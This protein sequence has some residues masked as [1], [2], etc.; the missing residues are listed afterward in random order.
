MGYV[1]SQE[2]SLF[3]PLK[4]IICPIHSAPKASV[5]VAWE[6]LLRLHG[7]DASWSIFPNVEWTEPER[8]DIKLDAFLPFPKSGS[9]TCEHCEQF[10][11][12]VWKWPKP[13][14]MGFGRGSCPFWD[15]IFSWARAM[16]LIFDVQ[17]SKSKMGSL[18][19]GPKRMFH[20]EMSCFC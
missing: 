11:K 2:G 7:V 12:K 13:W 5:H 18:H 16:M 14:K 17:G 6:S 1:S 3:V 9:G 20:L 19:V 10:V 8:N 15:R 4:E